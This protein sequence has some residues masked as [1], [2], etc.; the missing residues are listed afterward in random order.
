[1][2]GAGEVA[3]AAVLGV[4]GLGMG[5]ASRVLTERIPDRRS[6]LTAPFPEVGAALRSRVGWLIAFVTAGLF[7]ALTF[8]F[9]NGWELAAYLVLALALVV[10]SVI[11]LR[12]FVL[13]NRIVYPLA[14]AA[15][16]ALGVAAVAGADGDDVL[17]ALAGGAGAF[18]VFFVFHLVSPAAMGFGDVKLVFVLGLA[19]GWLGVGETV[20]GLFLGFVYG[21]VIGV[22]LIA[23]G[24]RS[25]RDHIPFGPFLAAGTMTAVLVGTTIVDWYR[26]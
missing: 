22:A 13:P 5:F 8:R 3:A 17:R 7:V 21:A 24:K 6:V 4:V 9:A 26:G 2:S 23:S 19:L 18:V 12:H 16:A 1:M 15:L 14:I 20:L 11:D 10:L 25:R